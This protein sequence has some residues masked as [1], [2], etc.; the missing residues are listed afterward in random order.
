MGMQTFLNEVASKVPTHFWGKLG[1]GVLIKAVSTGRYLLGKRSEYVNEPGTWG[2]FGGKIDDDED[3][4]RSAA[5]RELYEETG[6]PASEVEVHP[7]GTFTNGS[8]KFFNFLG[9]VEDEFEPELS[10]ETSESDWF[11]PGSFPSPIHFGLK[12]LI[13]AGKVK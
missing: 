7:L 4:P 6:L 3:D 1:A 13:D 11:E 12:A 10:W 9:L 2:G 8:F 5:L